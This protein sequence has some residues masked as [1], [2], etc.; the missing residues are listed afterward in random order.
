ML[1]QGGQCLA[2]E[3]TLSLALHVLRGQVS[4]LCYHLT[5]VAAETALNMREPSEYTFSLREDLQ[6]IFKMPK[7]NQKKTYECWGGRPEG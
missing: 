5:S 1:G 4:R 7:I 3:H 2:H 6:C